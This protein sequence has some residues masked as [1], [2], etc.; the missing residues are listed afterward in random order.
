MGEAAL[1]VMRSI[2]AGLPYSATMV[3]GAWRLVI[4][5]A[6]DHC[7]AGWGRIPGQDW[8][9]LLNGACSPSFT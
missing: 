1:S 9:R 6:I 3:L 2:E 5:S 7:S 8:K 4:A